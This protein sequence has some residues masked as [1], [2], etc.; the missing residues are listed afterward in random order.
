[1]RAGRHSISSGRTKEFPQ[2][3]RTRSTNVYVA[4]GTMATTSAEFQ[5]MVAAI[6]N[7]AKGRQAPP[8]SRPAPRQLPRL[9]T[10][11]VRLQC[12]LTRVTWNF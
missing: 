11:L 5:A 8:Q 10:E 9:A 4:I 12:G 7:I 2:L 6:A 1:M 3:R